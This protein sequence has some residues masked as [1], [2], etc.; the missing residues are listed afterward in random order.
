VVISLWIGYGEIFLI[1]VKI[2]LVLASIIILAYAS[3][4][5]LG[6]FEWF[7]KYKDAGATF[8][9][10]GIL[11]LVSL[12]LGFIGIWVNGYEKGLNEGLEWGNKE[13]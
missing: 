11:I 8:A 7:R 10:E 9:F 5:V 13:E 2:F 1:D 12:V 3:L 4:L 6:Q